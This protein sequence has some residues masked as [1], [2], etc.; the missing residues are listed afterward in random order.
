MAVNVPP[1]APC[2]RSITYPVAPVT[3]VKVTRNDV[4]DVATTATFVGAFGVLL[5]V[6][7]L[8]SPH[9]ESVRENAISNAMDPRVREIVRLI[10]HSVLVWGNGALAIGAS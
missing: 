4:E 8:S 3:P 10:S 5:P 1:V 9:A 2:A 7:G 6:G